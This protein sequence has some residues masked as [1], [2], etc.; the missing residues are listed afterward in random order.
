METKDLITQETILTFIRFYRKLE[1][2]PVESGLNLIAVFA[3]G[4]QKSHLQDKWAVQGKDFGRFFL[5]LSWRN[6]VKLLNV[7][8][9]EDP[10]DSTY[11]SLDER[12]PEYIFGEPPATV[13]ALKSLMVFFLNHGIEEKPSEGIELKKLPDEKKRYGDSTN[14]GDYI[15]SLELR[16][17]NDLLKIISHKDN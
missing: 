17:D 1:K 11:L 14:W 9:I 3:Q 7:W 2:A 5:N 15:L 4:N 13:K 16:E 8:G 10:D 6:K 12:D